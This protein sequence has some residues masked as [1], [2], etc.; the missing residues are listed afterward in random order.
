VINNEFAAALDIGTKHE[1][2]SK[3][4]DSATV[5]ADIYETGVCYTASP[6]PS[7][8]YIALCVLALI[9]D[10]FVWTKF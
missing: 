7:A 10:S 9:F 2:D 3:A 1:L 6:L 8:F 5:A 4:A